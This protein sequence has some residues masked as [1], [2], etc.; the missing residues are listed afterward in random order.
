MIPSPH[1]KR[2]L[3]Y[4]D[5][6]TWGQNPHVKG[7]RFA[8]DTRWTGI[9][10]QA[11]GD[12]YSIIEEGL[13]SRTTDLDYEQKPG[14][15]GRLYF[16]PCLESQNPLDLVVIMLGTNDY[17]VE[18]GPRPAAGI[19]RALR[20]YA[21]DVAMYAKNGSGG[22]PRIA[23]VSPIHVNVQALDFTTWYAQKYDTRAAGL[24]QALAPE[25][26]KIAEE[27]GSFFFDAGLVAKPGVDGIHMSV[28]G[29]K[30]LG[31]EIAVK[32]VDW[33]Q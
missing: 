14:R 23:L 28:E 9:A 17:K 3:C 11:L 4:G 33:L 30:A 8:A 19:A 31:R 18:F 15:N 6:N 29:H 22:T 32:I 27:T 10:Q 24:S 25:L 1:A 12:N 20:G 21:D 16:Q 13:S 26:Q 2:I 7:G 5:S